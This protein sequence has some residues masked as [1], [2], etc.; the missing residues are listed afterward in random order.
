MKSNGLLEQAPGF[1]T[2]QQMHKIAYAWLM[3]LCMQSP[4]G[5]L[6]EEPKE[7]FSVTCSCGPGRHRSVRD[8]MLVAVLH[9]QCCSYYTGA[10]LGLTIKCKSQPKQQK[11]M[12]SQHTHSSRWSLM[13]DSHKLQWA[14][15][16]TLMALSVPAEAT[17]VPSGWN[18]TV[19]T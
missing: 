11:H 15:L 8:T 5:E 3:I 18:A 7:L 17:Q 13:H 14:Q 12:A 10:S 9:S 19:L 1:D 6:F 2:C 16:L 4:L